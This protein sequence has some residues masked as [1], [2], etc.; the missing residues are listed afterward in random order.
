VRCIERSSGEH[1]LADVGFG[2]PDLRLL[3]DV[4]FG[5][6]DLRLLADV[7]FGEPDLRQA[8]IIS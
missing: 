3:A 2:E 4:G 7:G 5:E 8:I 6:P 1:A